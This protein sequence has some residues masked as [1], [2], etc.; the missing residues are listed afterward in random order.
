MRKYDPMKD[1][2]SLDRIAAAEAKARQDG[3]VPQ[4]DPVS[5]LLAIAKHAYRNEQIGGWVIPYN[6]IEMIQNGVE[7]ETAKKLLGRTPSTPQLRDI[8]PPQGAISWQPRKNSTTRRS[9]TR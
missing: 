2:E 6:A 3:S 7:R 4:A 9:M 5:I 1:H 8:V